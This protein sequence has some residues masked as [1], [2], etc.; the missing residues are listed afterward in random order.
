MK[1]RNLNTGVVVA[2]TATINHP[3]VSYGKAV[4]VDNNN[5]A[6]CQIGLEFIAG[7]ELVDQRKELG[8]KLAEIRE[9]KDMNKNFLVK[10]GMRI[11]AINAIEEGSKNYTIDSLTDYLD[12]VGIDM[13]FE[14]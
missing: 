1:L 7:F 6:Y 13:W 14:G 5:N 9:G 2:V 10:R 11:E 3:Q 12:I 4:W 8:Q